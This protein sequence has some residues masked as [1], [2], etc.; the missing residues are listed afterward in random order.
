ME[1]A[2]DFIQKRRFDILVTLSVLAFI[3]DVFVKR[4]F[5][6]YTI[7]ALYALGYAADGERSRTNIVERKRLLAK[8]LTPE[9]L[10]NIKF[11][12]NWEGTRKKGML[13]YALVDGGIFFG[14]ALCFIYSIL[15]LVLLSGTIDYIKAG[16]GK[17][18]NF[19]VYTYLAGFISAVVLYRILWSY[20]EQKFL[21]LT[22]P[23][24]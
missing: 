15:T 19:M 4:H 17:M 10:R 11:T 20:N 18:F 24:H 3:F 21:R 2:W 13:K 22:D 7:L 1:K 6:S 8:G 9:D 16:F 23:L 5:F 14:F 12:R